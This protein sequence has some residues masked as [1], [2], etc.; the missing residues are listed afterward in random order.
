MALTILSAPYS[1]CV[2]GRAEDERQGA[3]AGLLP[4]ERTSRD[5]GPYL[6]C[7]GTMDAKSVVGEEISW[8]IHCCACCN[9]VHI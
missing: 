8:S 7:M 5:S 3:T 9:S 6:A 2:D 4:E 1:W